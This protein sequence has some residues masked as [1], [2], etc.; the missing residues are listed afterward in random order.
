M[1]LL[2]GFRNL[3]DPERRDGTQRTGM[4]IR[5]AGERDLNGRA[6]IDS[7]AVMDTMTTKF[8]P[9]EA[10]SIDE[11]REIVRHGNCNPDS[12]LG[13]AGVMRSLDCGAQRADEVLRAMAIAGYVRPD[14]SWGRD[15]CWKLTAL[16]IRLAVEKKLTR[17]GRVKVREIVEE[18][19]RRAQ[20]INADPNRLQRITL[21]LFG[22]ALENRP[23]YGDVDI[24]ITYHRRNLPE[25]ERKRLTKELE[26]RQSKSERQ[27]F[28]GRITGAERQDSREIRAA[29]KQGVP[30]LSLMGDD[31]MELGTPFRWLVNHDMEKDVPAPVSD[32]IIR[33]MPAVMERKEPS[34]IPEMTLMQARHRAIADTTKV[35][36]EGLHIDLEDTIRLEE[37]L[38]TPEVTKDGRLQPKD[39]RHDPKIRFAGFHHICPIWREQIGGVEMLKK[40]LEWCD[41]HKVWVRDLFP[42][43]SISRHH[44]THVIRFGHV[45]ELI[46]VRIGSKSLEASL[47]PP[48]RVRVSKIDLA[49]AYAVARSLVRM[50]EEARCAKMPPFNADILIPLL[51]LDRLPDFPKLFKAGKFLDEAFPGLCRVE[52][53]RS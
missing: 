52:I 6:K 16:G 21:R 10:V 17:I 8:P 4:D 34:P 37:A 50:H 42:R 26:Q 41:E 27:T 15:F 28:L 32:T 23:D 18:L 25:D 30:H 39:L 14:M 7:S 5:D 45:G 13:L 11:A 49:G 35:P 19:V 1:P 43:I 40:S 12:R 20:T 9:I 48:N 33:P 38:W 29:L 3:A 47:M 2:D 46:Y 24:A 36:V 51:D 53:L 22:S 44:R 31:P